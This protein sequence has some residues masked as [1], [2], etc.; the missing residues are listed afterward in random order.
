MMFVMLVIGASSSLLGGALDGANGGRVGAAAAD[1]VFERILDLRIRGLRIAVDQLGRGQDPAADAIGALR[2][3]LLEP[4]GL[5][6]M[7]LLGRAEAGER[8]DL[9]A[10]EG[11]DRRDAGTH[12]MAVD[13]HRAGAALSEPATEARIVELELIAQG[14]E[15]RHVGV[16]DVDRARPAVDGECEPSHGRPPG[17]RSFWNESINSTSGCRGSWSWGLLGG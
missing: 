3:L 10:F 17:G 6:R 16:V 5:N 4:G 11:G 7:R 9:P 8:G 12:R 13:L 2:D 14:V 15:Q 1:E